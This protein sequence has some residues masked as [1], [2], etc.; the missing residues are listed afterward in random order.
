VN[1]FI[2][3]RRLLS[4]ARPYLRMFLASVFGMVLIAV[5]QPAIPALLKSLLD[6]SFVDKDPTL[7]KLMP[8]AII[9]IMMV[10]GI[11]SFLSQ[12]CASW[13]GNKVVLDLRDSMFK[14]LVQLPTAFFENTN[15]GNV[16]SKLTFDVAQVANAATN[17]LTVLIKDGLTILGL[18]LWLLYLNWKLTLI[19]LAFAPPIVII[20]VVASRRLRAMS[21]RAQSAMGEITRVLQEATE[22]H[23]VV[24]VFGGQQY[25]TR[26]FF[27][28][29]N[30][31]RR[32]LMK[33]AIT[34]NASW[35]MVQL[36][37]AIG[38][39]II[40]Y[41]AILQSQAA[42]T[43][44]GGFVSFVVAS[45]MLTPPLKRLT[46]INEHLQRGLAASESVF[47]VLDEEPEPDLGT[48]VLPHARGEIRFDRVSFGYG[49]PDNLALNDVSLSIKPGETVALVGP[50]G[51]GKT[52]LV[53][54]I[55]RFHHP[56]TGRISLDGHDLETLQLKS[57]RANVALVSQEVILFD[58]TVAAN[59]AYG[60]LGDTSDADII[61]A[62]KAAH[63]WEF[64]LEMPEQL[65]TLVGENGVKLSGGQRQRIAIARAFLKNAPVLI[66]D[67]ATSALDTE[68]ERH[69]QAALEDLLQGRTTIVI[70]H[71]LSTV[72][73]AGRI[74]VLDKG[75]VAELGT[76]R[77]LL[78]KNGLYAQL[79][80]VQFE[81]AAD[82]S[83]AEPKRHARA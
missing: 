74:V 70:A 61:A 26:R 8:L 60:V 65:Q 20:M 59:I 79:Y 58:D 46:G 30:S 10:H 57:L 36:V 71:R 12:Y 16:I 32:Y 51:S 81:P 50:S 29:A 3:Y 25:E 19:A 83:A 7:M 48:I 38:L 72:E 80:R 45:L 18:I 69:V 75:R 33:Q 42:E 47:L 9:L 17:V 6:G 39:A 24:K 27:E 63:A 2:L 13:V 28:R 21:Q 66:L 78:E 53:N 64:I 43:T 37:I 4:Y 73:K 1:S 49:D 44:V 67:E 22:A 55:P 31:L 62:A 82:S 76:H 35:P 14:K 54:L 52:T 56:T 40:V 68:S 11:G 23:K 77:D 34:A 5:T 15:S 41:L